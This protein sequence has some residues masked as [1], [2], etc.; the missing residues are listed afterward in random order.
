MTAPA[1][2]AALA[3]LHFSKARAVLSRLDA[4]FGVDRTTVRKLT[5]ADGGT[6][7]LALRLAI[8]E[9]EAQFA[10][11]AADRARLDWVGADEQ[12]GGGLIS[13]DRG[14]WAFSTT[15]MQSR[16]RMASGTASPRR[17]HE[18]VVLARTVR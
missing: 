10:A 9:A 7:C 14:R 4:H 1:P 5:R 3:A 18:R 11:L 17:R 12:D 6:C 13:D 2:D 16:T 8:A 15:G